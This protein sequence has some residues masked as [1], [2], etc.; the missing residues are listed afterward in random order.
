MKA[1]E[2]AKME[3]MVCGLLAAVLVHG[4]P[5]VAVATTPRP[6]PAATTFTTQVLAEPPNISTDEL[7]KRLRTASDLYLI[8]VRSKEAHEQEHL[9]GA[10]SLPYSQLDTGQASLP[11]NRTL[12]LYCA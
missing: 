3:R 4:I 1:S 2:V 12:V 7:H 9:P 10:H 11:R 5:S 6:A 8:D